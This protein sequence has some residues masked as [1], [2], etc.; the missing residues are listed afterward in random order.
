MNRNCAL[1]LDLCT[2]SIA[3]AALRRAN[4][5]FSRA[6]AIETG[7]QKA[8][9]GAGAPVSCAGSLS[10]DIQLRNQMCGQL[11][12]YLE[13][14]EKKSVDGVASDGECFRTVTSGGGVSCRRATRKSVLKIQEKE[15]QEN[16]RGYKNR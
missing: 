10:V 7:G 12:G 2:S 6:V 11:C 1:S 9:S 13:V 8:S 5:S 16:A 14:C 4:F 3:S 15:G